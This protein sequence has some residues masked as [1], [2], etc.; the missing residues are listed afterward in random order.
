MTSASKNG[1]IL[2]SSDDECDS[3]RIIV[4]RKKINKILTK[5]IKTLINTY[6]FKHI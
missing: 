1:S 6:T 4:L 5:N 2:L 3:G